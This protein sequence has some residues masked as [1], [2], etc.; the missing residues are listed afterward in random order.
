MILEH[1]IIQQKSVVSMNSVGCNF[2]Y[3]LPNLGDMCRASNGVLVSSRY[4]YGKP[5][6]PLNWCA[7]R[8]V[9][10]R[11]NIKF[12][13]PGLVPGIFYVASCSFFIKSHWCRD[14]QIPLY[15]S[16]RRHGKP[17]K[18]QIGGV[19]L[20]VSR[21]QE[22]YSLRRH[23]SKA[24]KIICTGKKFQKWKSIMIQGGTIENM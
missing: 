17:K 11:K 10:N 24:L 3:N 18:L 19:P 8:Q 1:H 16:V 21:K 15:P 13:L 6:K 14:A 23:G 22:M 2:Y 20:F 12:F 5:R 4:G 7:T 9:D